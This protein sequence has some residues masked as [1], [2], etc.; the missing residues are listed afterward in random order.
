MV[1]LK[2]FS[3]YSLSI[4]INKK[5]FTFERS[6]DPKT[7]PSVCF[8]KTKVRYLIKYKIFYF[9]KDKKCI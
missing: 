1:D 2:I 6:P 5:I 7:N 4:T 8:F 9:F 3:F